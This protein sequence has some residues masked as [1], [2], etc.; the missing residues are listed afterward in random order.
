MKILIAT[1]LGGV[2]WAA[3]AMA[4]TYPPKT[5]QPT[6]DNSATTMYHGSGDASFDALDSNQDGFLS[7]EEVMGN[8]SMAQNFARLDTN[9]DGKISLDEWQAMGHRAK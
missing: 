6:K 5:P 8:P 1:T 7:K 3:G 4:Q 2:L 9:G